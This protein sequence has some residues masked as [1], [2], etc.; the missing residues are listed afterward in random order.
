MNVKFPVTKFMV[1]FLLINFGF[2]NQIITEPIDNWWI[3]ELMVLIVSLYMSAER[4]EE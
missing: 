2:V 1:W 3:I 4:E